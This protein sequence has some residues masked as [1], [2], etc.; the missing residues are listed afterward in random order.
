MLAELIPYKG[1]KTLTS[2]KAVSYNVKSLTVEADGSKKNMPADA[3]VL[4]V[5]YSSEN[6]LHNELKNEVPDIRLIGDARNVS[7]LCMQSANELAFHID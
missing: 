1:G 2:S 7:T 6:V 3:V 4:A 5:G